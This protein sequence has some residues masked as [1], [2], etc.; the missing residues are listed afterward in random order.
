MDGRGH[1]AAVLKTG[2]RKH[3]G[4]ESHPLRHSLQPSL[5][6]TA[7]LFVKTNARYDGDNLDI[8]RRYMPDASVDLGVVITIQDNRAYRALVEDARRL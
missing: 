8:L 1:A 6:P 2:V 5:Q 4:F 7:R 3:R